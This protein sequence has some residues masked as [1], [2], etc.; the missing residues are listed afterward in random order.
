M[1]N[2]TGSVLIGTSILLLCATAL[3]FTIITH[4]KEVPWFKLPKARK[5]LTV[6]AASVRAELAGLPDFNETR[7]LDAYG[8]H[9]D[10]LP[11][12]DGMPESPRWSA[13]VTWSSIA[14]V[15]QVVLVPA[16][17]PRQGTLHGYGFPRR[18][19]VSKQFKDGTCETVAEWM[20]EDCPDPTHVPLRIDIPAPQCA[21]IRIDVYRGAVEGGREFFALGEVFCIIEKDIWRALK[22]VA[23]PSFESRPYW[24]KDYLADQKTG[25]G[26]PLGLARG[27][28]GE[29]ANNA[30]SVTFEQPPK[31]DCLI[32]LDLGSEQWMGWLTLFPATP[33]SG[34]IVPG[35]GF[36]GKIEVFGAQEVDGRTSWIPIHKAE[37][38][39]GNPGDNPVRIPLFG[40]KGRWLRLKV[41]GFAERNGLKILALSEASISMREQA[42]PVKAIRLHGF[43]EEAERLAGFLADGLASGR[44]VL[45]MIEWLNLIERQSRLKHRLDEIVTLDAEMELR[46]AKGKGRAIIASATLALLLLLIWAVHRQLSLQRLKLRIAQERSQTEFEQMKLRLFSQISHELRTPL[47]VI[48]VPIERAMKEVGEGKLKTYLG[49]ALKNVYELQQLVEQILDLR[50]IQDGQMKVNPVEVELV[51]HISSIIDSMRPLAEEKGIELSFEPVEESLLARIDPQAL[52][53]MLGNLISN[54]IKFTPSAGQVVVGFSTIRHALIFFVEDTGPGIAAEDLP[55]IFDQHYRGQSSSA[56]QTIGSGL[57]LALVHEVAELLSGRVVVASPIADGQGSRFTIEI[58]LQKGDTR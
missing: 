53:R 28:Q 44:P 55:H 33:P 6:E 43:P 35:Y 22:I 49:V 3:A 14:K 30:F 21:S 39:G 34:S 18:F 23:E 27:N 54:A 1:R 46:W 2:R 17:D 7:Q 31:E 9:G 5:A 20:D 8:F 10:Y 57:G 32:E 11:V 4:S 16:I 36:P 45:Q 26:M 51:V 15:E 13:E 47:T 58:P 29:E 37:W 19:R 25:L 52:K 12:I 50:R 40:F 48:P 38:T 42:H 41:S 56:R 24:S